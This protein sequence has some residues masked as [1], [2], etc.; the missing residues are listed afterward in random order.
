[1]LPQHYCPLELAAA[2]AHQWAVAV[3]NRAMVTELAL[4]L[5]QKTILNDES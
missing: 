4:A 5:M 3:G 2:L 1:L